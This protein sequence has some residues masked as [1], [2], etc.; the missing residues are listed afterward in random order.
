VVALRAGDA[1]ARRRFVYAA[2]VAT[3]LVVR[4]LQLTCVLV[5]FVVALT[6]HLA[7]G[8]E[9]NVANDF[10]DDISDLSLVRNPELVVCS[11]V[12]LDGV[13]KNLSK[14]IELPHELVQTITLAPAPLPVFPSITF[15]GNLRD[16][17]VLVFQRRA[18]FF[19][20]GWEV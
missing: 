17:Q 6:E 20:Y 1:D 12:C 13:S 4:S 8:T 9:R 5:D 14:Q 10:V 19:E 15:N 7:D 2:F 16:I 3:Q 11:C 18:D